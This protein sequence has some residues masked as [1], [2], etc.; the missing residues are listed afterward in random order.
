MWRILLDPKTWIT[1]FNYTNQE[2]GFVES[3]YEAYTKPSSLDPIPSEED[4]MLK[5]ISLFACLDDDTLE[6]LQNTAIR[7]RYPKNTVLFSKGDFSDS[8]YVVVKGK[9]KA[10]IYN[11]EGREMLLSFFGPGEYFGEIS[12]LDGQPRSASMVTKTPCQ[13]LIIGG[14]EVKRVLFSNP[15]M[16]SRLL[17]QTL[18]KLRDATDRI[19]NITFLNVYGR[20]VNL[21]LQQARPKDKEITL[22]EKLTHQEIANIVGSSREMVSRVMKELVQGG[23]ITVNRKNIIIKRKLPLEF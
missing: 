8:M 9:V 4:A 16:V 21:F 7:R 12:M 18:G 15:E 3:I 23:Y 6:N 1:I 19:E 5:K 13:L 20:I 11:E 22:H 17:I 10:V 2:L 14:K